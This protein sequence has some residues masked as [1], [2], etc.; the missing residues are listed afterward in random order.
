LYALL[1]GDVAAAFYT[2]NDR[3]LPTGWI[4]RMRESLARLTPAFSSNRTVREYTTRYYVPAARAYHERTANNARRGAEVL[5]WA[6]ALARGWGTATFRS[7][8]VHT[9]GDRHTF[10]VRLNLGDLNPDDVRVE[11]YADGQGGGAPVCQAMTR[12]AMTRTASETRSGTDHVYVALV[13]ASRPASDFTP[14]LVPFHADAA[15]PLEA[16]FILWYR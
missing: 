1:E 6:S 14:R 13:A 16:P 4:A 12:Q 7:M 9:D 3:G 11:L 2:R 5:A 15:V 8:D 10:Q